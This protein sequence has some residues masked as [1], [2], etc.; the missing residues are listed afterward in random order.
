M[1]VLFISPLAR[2]SLAGRLLDHGYEVVTADSSEIG[3][4]TFCRA[5]IDGVPFDS[6]VA[7]LGFPGL[8][9]TKVIDRI[10]AIAPWTRTVVLTEPDPVSL[11]ALREALGEA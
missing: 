10:L 4:V 9:G 2:H 6:V 11:E 5:A 1:R 8:D 3:L 7:E